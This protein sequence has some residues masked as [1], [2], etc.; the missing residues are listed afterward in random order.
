MLIKNL[1]KLIPTYLMD[2]LK[3]LSFYTIAPFVC[4]DYQQLLGG[5][6]FCHQQFF[7][8]ILQQYIAAYMFLATQIHIERYSSY[9][10][11]LPGSQEVI[12][13]SFHYNIYKITITLS[14]DTYIFWITLLINI[15]NKYKI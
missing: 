1:Q 6:I 5:T 12:G 15:Y 8:L 9:T 2:Q 11:F 13:D 14:I 10:T 4:M 7:L 3:P